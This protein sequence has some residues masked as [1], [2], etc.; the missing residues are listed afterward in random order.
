M[1]FAVRLLRD[2]IVRL[3]LVFL[4]LSLFSF[5]VLDQVFLR[6]LYELAARLI[7]IATIGPRGGL[8]VFI[9]GMGLTGWASWTQPL[10]DDLRRMRR[11]GFIEAAE[12]IG[13]PPFHR[14][15]RHMVPNLPPLMIPK[16][17]Q[18]VGAAMVMLAEYDLALDGA[19]QLEQA[20][21]R[22][23]VY[24]AYLQAAEETATIEAWHTAA[25]M[26]RTVLPVVAEAA[27][28]G[29]LPLYRQVGNIDFAQGSFQG[30]IEAY[31]QAA[32][33]LGAAP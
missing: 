23:R 16:S 33:V 11:V 15:L 30:A 14:F 7:V 25:T 5:F 2:T 24:R 10:G 4:A 3:L 27:P 21:A 32:D 26:Y 20:T 19:P 12:A 29:K 8:P 13:S 28:S 17:V 1:S 18:E 6:H 31:Q 22:Q 9:A